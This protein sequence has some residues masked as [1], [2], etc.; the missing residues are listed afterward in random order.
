MINAFSLRPFAAFNFAV[1]CGIGFCIS[2]FCLCIT[3][4]KFTLM[5]AIQKPTAT[6]AETPV[7]M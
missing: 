1:L 5:P 3:N 4:A 6:S 7:N 2:A